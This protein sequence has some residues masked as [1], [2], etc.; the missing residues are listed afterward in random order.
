MYFTFYSMLFLEDKLKIQELCANSQ[1]TMLKCDCI[2]FC[3]S[4]REGIQ[5]D[6]T[7]PFRHGKLKSTKD[8]LSAKCC[9]CGK[10]CKGNNFCHPLI[11]SQLISDLRCSCLWNAGKS[12]F[13][14]RC[15]LSHRSWWWSN[16]SKHRP[17]KIF[18]SFDISY[19]YLNLLLTVLAGGVRLQAICLV[20]C[21]LSHCVQA[22]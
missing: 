6:E 19:L 15:S 16:Q 13:L 10:T 3:G 1:S 21:Q 17:L 20:T 18:K 2:F 5:F 4:G 22:G 12:P 11:F 14:W 9:R 8:A 7:M